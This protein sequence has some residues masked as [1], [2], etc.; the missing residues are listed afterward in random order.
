MGFL[1]FISLDAIAE[2][3]NFSYYSLNGGEVR[4]NATSVV[5]GTY[6]AE[7]T[8]ELWDISICRKTDGFICFSGEQALIAVPVNINSLVGEAKTCDEPSWKH[9]GYTFKIVTQ[10][11]HGIHSCDQVVGYQRRNILSLSFDAVKVER[12]DKHNDKNSYFLWSPIKGLV[13]FTD[14]SGTE[15]WLKS[16]C[17]FG[18]SVDCKY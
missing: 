18:A 14:I 4:I 12:I 9:K 1:M 15:Y 17:G 6:F 7:Y 5:T 11:D 10:E 8:A 13:A 2:V 16:N 3:D